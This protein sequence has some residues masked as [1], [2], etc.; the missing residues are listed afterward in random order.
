M[1]KTNISRW[2]FNGLLL[3]ATT[4]FLWPF[5]WMVTGSLKNLTVS[6]QIPP[7]WIPLHPTMINYHTLF[8]DYSVMKWFFNSMLIAACASVLVLALS[9]MA[10]YAIAKI[11]FKA[12]PYLF[13]LMI[14]TLTLPHAVMFIPLF[15]MM[16]QLHL[17]NTYAAA[18]LPIIGWPFGVFLLRQIMVTLPTPLIEAARID[19][20]SELLIFTRLILPLSKPGLAVLAIFTFVNAWND[21][22]WQLLVLTKENML[23][24]P[25]GVRVVQ[26][27]QEFHDNYG[28]AMAGAVLATLPLI[29]LFIFFQKYFTKG[30]TLG[31]V[32]G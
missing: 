7:E 30:I 8:V 11:Q 5:Y 32:K 29:A 22:V 12:G 1:E 9:S 2:L 26:K 18:I 19:G 23:T 10:A 17:I 16:N 14:G 6:I 4:F 13:A 31:A 28:I 15:Q 20:G 25:V 24:L 21:Y 3:L 27:A